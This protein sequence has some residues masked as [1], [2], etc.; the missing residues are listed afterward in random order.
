MRN[1]LNSP[2]SLNW[3]NKRKL[4]QQIQRL[5]K[6][7]LSLEERLLLLLSDVSEWKSHAK[8]LSDL[9]RRQLLTAKHIVDIRPLLQQSEDFHRVIR[10]LNLDKPCLEL[11]ED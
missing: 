4:T 9:S 11:E 5:E 2:G 8:T 1:W 3:A 10:M 6:T 7:V